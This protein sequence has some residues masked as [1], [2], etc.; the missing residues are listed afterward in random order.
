MAI[1]LVGNFLD[2]QHL[3]KKWS[4]IFILK[5]ARIYELG[6]RQH[7]K[8]LLNTANKAKTKVPK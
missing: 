4:L 7:L 8:Y 1:D 5:L 2:L 3:P 6:Y